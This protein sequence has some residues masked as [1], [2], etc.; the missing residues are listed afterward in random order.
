[1]KYIQKNIYVEISSF[2]YWW[3][4]Y[5]F[6]DLEGWED[7][8]FYEKTDQ[9]YIRL[10][11]TCVCTKNYLRDGLE[12]LENDADEL[13][14]VIKIKEHLIGNEI[15]YHYYYDS[16]NDEDFFELSY[17]NLPK[18][19]YNI[20]PRSFEIWHP[21]EVINQKTITECVKVICSRFLNI[22]AANIEY[23]EAITF[24]EASA[25]YLEEQS[26]WVSAKDFVFTDE[27]I[28]N[29][30]NKMS[31]TKDEILMILNKNI[32]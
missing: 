3:G 31:K 28:D 23:Y 26:R 25:S 6:S 14:F 21:D 11:S 19:E 12:D 4:I 9:D 15:H 13:D 24:E 5:G 32:K 20:K 1:M 7:I 27:L 29:L 18:N 2:N 8:V 10:G 16:P 17:E 22:E 30:M